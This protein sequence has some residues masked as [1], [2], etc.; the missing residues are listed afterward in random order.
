MVKLVDYPDSSDDEQIPADAGMKSDSEWSSFGELPSDSGDSFSFQMGS[1]EP[2]DIEK[3]EEDDGDDGDEDYVPSASSSS[4]P[5][6]SPSSSDLEPSPRCSFD[7]EKPRTSLFRGFSA[8]DTDTTTSTDE[9]GSSEE[10]T[11]AGRTRSVNGST[12][13]S[14]KSDSKTMFYAWSDLSAA[15]EENPFKRRSVAPGNGSFTMKSN[16]GEEN[17]AAEMAE[18]HPENEN[19]AT[20]SPMEA[21]DGDD[22]IQTYKDDGDLTR[23]LETQALELKVQFVKKNNLD[24]G[25]R[26]GNVVNAMNRFEDIRPGSPPD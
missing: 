19:M 5:P 8:A 9:R 15:F 22:E 1:P 25:R 12:A 14:A 20:T 17:K 6:S 4:P 2:S 7:E 11:A 10:S 18:D 24:L 13:N 21:A 16:V 23:L 3:D 26:R